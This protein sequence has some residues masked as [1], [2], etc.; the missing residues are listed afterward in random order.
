MKAYFGKIGRGE[1][2]TAKHALSREFQFSDGSWEDKQI[3][4][5]R[6][7]QG[8]IVRGFTYD[9]ISEVIEYETDQRLEDFIEDGEVNE[10]AIWDAV[11][12]HRQLWHGS[13]EDVYT[14]LNEWDGWRRY[15][16]PFTELIAVGVI[17]FFG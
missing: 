10:S 15:H 3:W 2:E 5:D 1:I 16:S 9:V 4:F 17:Q 11:G 7:H 13:V 8:D 12:S 6:P 14:V